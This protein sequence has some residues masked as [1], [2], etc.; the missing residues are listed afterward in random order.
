MFYRIIQYFKAKYMVTGAIVLPVI[1]LV[2]VLLN[3]PD[4]LGLIWE[5]LDNPDAYK[6]INGD[7]NF[8]IYVFPDGE[9]IRV[10]VLPP[11]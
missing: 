6:G 7:M 3:A 11:A 8:P 5:V 10:D 9:G 2:V 4:P 1:L